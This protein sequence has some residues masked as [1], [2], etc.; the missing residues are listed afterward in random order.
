MNLCVFVKMNPESPD[1]LQV[2]SSQA[3]GVLEGESDGPAYEAGTV[4][5]PLL[6]GTENRR[7][8][9][10]ARLDVEE[11]TRVSVGVDRGVQRVDVLRSDETGGGSGGTGVGEADEAYVLA[12]YSFPSSKLGGLER[13]TFIYS[14]GHQQEMRAL[15]EENQRLRLQVEQQR[16]HASEPTLQPVLRGSNPPVYPRGEGQD[17]ELHGR[18][19]VGLSRESAEVSDNR[20]EV[21]EEQGCVGPPPGLQGGRGN[22]AGHRGPSEVR[23]GDPVEAHQGHEGADGHPLSEQ[24]NRASAGGEATGLDEDVGTAKVFSGDAAP[25]LDGGGR[26]ATRGPMDAFGLLA[27]GIAQLQTAMSATMAHKAQELEVVKPGISELPRLPELSETS[28]ID[29]GDWVHALECPMIDLSNGTSSWWKETLQCLDRFYDA[30]LK[31]SNIA[32]LSLK[33]EAFATAFLKEE[34]WSRVDKRATS[35]ILTALPEAVKGEILASRLTGTLAVMGRVMVL[36]RPGSAAERQQILKALE[37]PSTAGTA[38]EAVDLLR[39]WSRWLRRAGDVGL[40]C[41]DASVLVRGLDT[42]TRK[43]IAE[44][45]EIQFRMNMMRYTLEVDSKPTKKVVEDL[46]HAMLSEFE[47]VAFRGRTKPAPTATSKTMLAT[48]TPSPSATTTSRESGTGEASPVKSKTAPCKFFLTEQGC[49]KGQHCKFSHEVDKKQRQ[50]RCWTCGSKLHMSKQCPTKD[51]PGASTSPSRTATRAEPTSPTSVLAAMA[52]ES[53]HPIPPSGATST[54]APLPTATTTTASTTGEVRGTSA[55]TAATGSEGDLRELLREANSMLKEMRQLKMLTVN[56]VLAQARTSGCNNDGGRTGLLDSGASHPFRQGTDVELGSADKVKV[57]LAN[58]QEIVLAQN[59]AGTLLASSSTSDDASTP[60]V[61]LG[62]L[63]QDLNCELTWGRRRGL[64]IKHPVHGAIRPRVVGRCP[65]IGETQALDLIR[66]LEDQRVDELRRTTMST[67]RALWLWDE[68]ATWSRC[69][70]RFLQD[71]TRVQQLQALE[72]ED[73]PF[74]GLD[75]STKSALAEELVLNNK[76]GWNYLKALPISRR[77]RK[78]L[79]TSQWI[80]NLFA[81]PNPAAQEFKVLED[82][83]VLVE[84]D[85]AR[86]RAHDLRKSHGAYRALCWAAAT[87]RI[88]GMLASPPLR[89]PD[90]EELVAKAMWCSTIVKAANHFHGTVSPFVMIEGRKLMDYVF[91]EEEGRARSGLAS[92]WPSYLEAMSIERQ[93]PALVSNL[94]Y[95]NLPQRTTMATGRWSEEFIEATVKAVQEWKWHPETRQIKRWLAKMDAG[96]FLGSLTDR[97]LEQ[98][99]AHVR[100]NHLPY[101]RKCR[102]CVE[103]SGTGRKHARIKT[104]PSYCLSLDVCGPFR[105]RGVDPDH[106]DYRFALVGAYVIPIL[107]VRDGG[108]QGSDV[109]DGGPQEGDVRDG[110]P[111]EGDV[112]DGGPQ[113]SDV[114]D[115][116]PHIVSDVHTPVHGGDFVPEVAEDLGVGLGPLSEWKEG[117]LVE[118]REDPPLTAEEETRLP[119]GMTQAEF[120]EIFSQVGVVEGYKVLYVSAPLRSRTTKDVLYAV[121]DLYLRL[122]AQGCPISRVHADRARELRSDPLKRWLASRGTYTTYTEGQSPQENGRAE[123]A[124]KYAKVQTKRLLRMGNFGPKMWPMALRYAMWAQMQKQLYPD[125][126]IIPFGT[127][128][129]VKRKVYGVGNRYDLESRWGMGYYLGPSMDVN[130]GSVIMM[131]KVNFIT[132]LHMRPN[133]IDADREVELEDYHAVVSVPSKRLRRKATLDPGN[134][135]EFHPLPPPA[136]DN[137]NEPVIY[138]PNHP[139]EE[140]ARAVLKEGRLERDFVESLARLLPQ[141]GSK[142]KRF[143]EKQEDE[144]IW[145]SGAFVHGG[146]VGLLNN[147]KKFPRTT[148]VFLNYL[149]SQCPDFKCNSLAVFKGVH[150][151]LHRDAHNVGMN[152]VVPLSDFKGCDV[153]VKRGGSEVILKVSDGP[154]Y[155]DPRE[156]HYTTECTEGVSWMLVAYSI[157]D[158]AKLKHEAVEYLEDLGFTWDPHR[159]REDGERRETENPRIAMMKAQVKFEKDVAKEETAVKDV[160]SGLDLVTSDLDLAIQD[161]EDRAARLRDLLEEEEIM[162]EQANRLGQAVREEMDDTRK[163][164]CKYLDDVH[165]QLMQF[166]RLRER[167]FLRSARQPEEADQTIDYE[168]LLNELEG[169]LDIVHTVPLDQVK[170]VLH[171]WTSAIEKEIKALF[172]SGTLAKISHERARELEARGELKVVPAKCVFTLKPT[173]EVGQKCRRKCRMV[174]CGNHIA[175][176]GDDQASLYAAGTS[177][178]ALRLALAVASSRRWLAAIADITSAFLLAEWPPGMPQYALAQPKVIRDSGD[179]GPELWLVQRPL[180]GLRESPMIWSEFRN[181]KLRLIEIDH[182]GKKLRLHQAVSES[183]LWLLREDG[184][185]ELYGLLVV[186]VDD[187]MYLAEPTVVEQLHKAIT[188]MWPASSLEWID[189]L[190]GVRYLGVEIKQDPTSKAFSISQQAYIAEL[191]RAHNMQD[192][193]HTQLPVP[194][195]WLESVELGRDGE[196]EFTEADLKLGQRFV[197]EALW[198][199]TKTRPDILY[200]VNAMASHVARRPLQIIKMGERLMAYLAGTADLELVLMPPPED[201]RPVMT[202]FT[203]ASFA[204]FGARS[205]GAAVVVYGKAPVSWKAGKQSFTTMST[206]EAELYAAVQGYVLLQSVSSILKELKLGPFDQVL[207]IDNSSAVAMCSGGPGSQRTRH[208]KVRANLI[209]EAVSTGDLIVQHTPGEEQLADLATKLV[210]KDRLWKL[211]GLWGFVGGKVTRMMDAIKL[212]VMIFLMTL[213][214]LV[215]PTTGRSLNEDDK[216]DIQISGWDELLVVSVMLCISAIACWELAKYVLRVCWKSYKGFKRDLK[217]NHVRRVAAEAARREVEEADRGSTQG[218]SQRFLEE[219]VAPLESMRETSQGPFRRRTLAEPTT[220]PSSSSLVT[221]GLTMSPAGDVPTNERVRV[222]KDTLSLLTVEKLREALRFVGLPVTGI[223][224]DLVDRLHPQL[225]VDEPGANSSQ[226][227]TKQLKYV[228]YLWRKRDLQGR[229]SLSWQD[230]AT[231]REISSWIYRHK[232]PN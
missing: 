12:G 136:Q 46:H 132:T 83:C 159:S 55:P 15:E 56:D 209:R 196:V 25:A 67:Q 216:E 44:H 111:Q 165:H 43:V 174:I 60:I 45:G 158:S 181:A 188:S 178:D 215:E 110:G 226:P 141:G 171:R 187:L 84:I 4:G 130:E 221:E 90:D 144:S 117:D 160:S 7:D 207:A 220:P 194:R 19:Q 65:I 231:R 33:P 135:E 185:N 213:V 176:D 50:G 203:D 91:L 48:V 154:Q 11:T 102:T 198:L 128:V 195:E 99:R 26:A 131:D 218:R 104:P 109:R 123:A 30:Y 22:V 152:A 54:T 223:K 168:E 127:R 232:E 206:M 116:G 179:Y 61:P 150:A 172:D 146:V 224:T 39:R 73:S 27:Q 57:Q 23:G 62:A 157:R 161:M 79:M 28:C 59:K 230:I 2:M 71:G 166:Q 210:T 183:E 101:N 72:A 74:A 211:L 105:H 114:R 112:R 124:V 35:M 214:S 200:T 63:V 75:A 58:G 69:L 5:E 1:L 199:A 192:T 47:Q 64:E 8:V 202:C 113:G 204:P 29:I 217:L 120:Q 98:W 37:A 180:Y 222:V 164:V 153:V 13:H 89:S 88:S 93:G 190:K 147:T 118:E 36:Y 167:A 205:Y 142:P 76:A 134:Y 125:K 24:R 52:P 129:H 155:F 106:A 126:P 9:P 219:P 191:L 163:Y 140:Y 95:V 119:G 20:A 17:F 32:K 41:P 10:E 108:P 227:T 115:G 103:S 18:P 70:E 149:K 169:D 228:L 97:E 96:N 94:D 170:R 86:S 122:R 184:T 40:Q 31:S 175:R 14:G 16:T 78:Q 139:A 173:N 3:P 34:K 51:K 162:A 177:T 189:N 121:Q 92:V 225:G 6:N 77:K 38:H 156:E 82:G 229:I 186:Y 145:A 197:G 201:A 133:L 138:D 100:N 143:G 81:G 42:V 80:V 21:R 53:A 85:I 148:K 151:E 193:A 212:K 87:G 68:K 66:E 107:D 182:R 49:K 208:L 137:D